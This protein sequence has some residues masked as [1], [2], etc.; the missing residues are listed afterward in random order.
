MRRLVVPLL[1]LEPASA[2]RGPCAVGRPS[3]ARIPRCAAPDPLRDVARWCVERDSSDIMVSVSEAATTSGLLR[4]FWHVAA[5]MGQAETAQQR[6]L[7]YPRWTAPDSRATFG[8][9]LNHLSRASEV[10]EYVG[11]NLY[12]S[13][14][15]PAT[16]AEDEAPAPCPLFILRSRP[17]DGVVFEDDDVSL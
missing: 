15:H 8:R 17:A 1:C 3:R 4:D 12:Y 11:E 7:A 2:L 13:A 5:E 14:R 10:C 9:I 16:P 6:I